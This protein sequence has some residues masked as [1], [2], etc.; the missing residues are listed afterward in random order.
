MKD[1]LQYLD[2]VCNNKDEKTKNKNLKKLFCLAYIRI[3]IDKFINI[4]NDHLDIDD[5][6]EIIE[7][8]N[9][10]NNNNKSFRKM[11]KIY[12]YKII[13][14]IN[15]RDYQCMLNENIKNKFKLNLFKGYDEFIKPTQ[16]PI[17]L[18]Y[19]L[20]PEYEEDWRYYKEELEVYNKSQTG[21]FSSIDIDKIKQFSKYKN[22][23]DI[24]YMI[25]ANLV[26]SYILDQS[27]KEKINNFWN[28]ICTKIYKGNELKLLGTLFNL[29]QFN[30]IKGEEK[31]R[32]LFWRP[33]TGIQNKDIEML[34]YALRFCFKTFTSTKLNI[35]YKIILNEKY[36]KIKDSYYPGNDISEDNYY[37][38]DSW[39]S[40]FFK[41]NNSY[42]TGV[43]ICACKEGSYKVIQPRG[44]P[45]KDKNK[46]DHCE[47]CG[48]EI[49]YHYHEE[50]RTRE[51]KEKQKVWWFIYKT[52]KKTITE[53]DYFQYIVKRDGY[54]RVFKDENHIRNQS[55][56]YEMRNKEI[57][58]MTYDSF[59]KE[60][61]DKKY[62]DEK[63]GIIQV[64]FSH[65]SKND[66]NI[67]H[68]KSQIS[69]RLLNF[70]LYSHLYFSELM[71][72]FDKNYLNK[73]CPKDR[74]N[75]LEILKKNWELL[76]DE[77]EN[78][79]KDIRIFMNL[80]FKDLSDILVKTEKINSVKNLYIKENELEEKIFQ[81]LK[82]YDSYSQKYTERNRIGRD[83]NLNSPEIFLKETNDWKLYDEKIIPFHEYLFYSE[84]VN[85][86][87]I[88][89]QADSNYK[90]LSDYKNREKDRKKSKHLETLDIYNSFINLVMNSCKNKIKREEAEQKILENED[91]YKNNSQICENFFKKKEEISKG[92]SNLTEKDNLTK[93]ILDKT[94]EGKILR[95]I[96]E[97]YIKEQNDLVKDLFKNKVD[98]GCI[99]KTDPINIQSIT[100]KEIFSW[101]LNKT[102]FTE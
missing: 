61:I 42:D 14:N 51:T 10:Y 27:S 89:I 52:V 58:Y 15:D 86:K 70:I 11:T 55:N 60:Y 45:T 62:E 73:F 74:Q 64:K 78:K 53:T 100:S 44:F 90:I 72:N 67:R 88:N 5:F 43:Y 38:I 68:L 85:E 31:P 79:G 76:S 59:K 41:K 69:Y 97:V 63:K 57:N 80:I 94:G 56:Q 91:F 32:F 82:N 35:I 6:S 13:Y 23:N 96:Y 75:C 71:G 46:N 20:L 22:A 18:E 21:D 16:K 66:K 3:Y 39:L 101:K 9:G 40:D 1:S 30:K 54:F 19:F 87:N 7:I 81:K 95:D 98:N 34:L 49:G 92:L 2:S 36:E 4:V 24:F 83:S 50:H 93:F 25:G 47:K 65:F 29:D 33:S 84:L 48:K 26:A 99:P 8:I 17:S 12:L 77:L 102:S 37:Y 28:N